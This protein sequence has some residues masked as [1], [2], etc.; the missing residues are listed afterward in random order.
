MRAVRGADTR[1]EMVV[2]RLVHR[3]GYRYRLHVRALPGSP[4]LVFPARRKVILVHGCFWHRHACKEGRSTPASRVDYWS[5][6]F[7]KNVRRD[8]QNRRRLRKLG[9]QVLVVWECQTLSRGAERL[10]KRL[11]EFLGSGD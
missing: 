3:L 4:D 5:E 8:Y 2:R 9:W 1:P 11:S 6:K 7:A 10:H